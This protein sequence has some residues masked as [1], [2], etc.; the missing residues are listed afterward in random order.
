MPTSLFTKTF[1][2]IINFH[3]LTSLTSLN[4]LSKLSLI[5]KLLFSMS[6]R[7]FRLDRKLLSTKNVDKALRASTI[8]WQI[9]THLPDYRY[10]FSPGK[11]ARY[12]NP[13]TLSL[14]SLVSNILFNFLD[15]GLFGWDSLPS[16]ILKISYV[17]LVPE[18]LETSERSWVLAWPCV[19][20]QRT[21][22]GPGST[23]NKQLF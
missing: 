18:P 16:A 8:S 3:H 5:A 13:V 7:K 21:G 14:S 15:N 10:S 1:N 19:A 9:T 17:A 4:A 6:P 11:T 22:R 12:T 23:Y 2:E 20:H